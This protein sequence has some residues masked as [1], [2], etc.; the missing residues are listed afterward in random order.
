LNF[1]NSNPAKITVFGKI[2]LCYCC[3]ESVQE[4]KVPAKIIVLILFFHFVIN[5]P[6]LS[7]SNKKEKCNISVPISNRYNE[8]H[9]YE[10]IYS[11]LVEF[12]LHPVATT[13]EKKI[14]V[15]GKSQCSAKFFL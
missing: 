12:F 7:Y 14:P 8:Q 2:P 10:K 5:G 11:I 13:L 15:F 4:I 6:N 9:T 1:E 3:T